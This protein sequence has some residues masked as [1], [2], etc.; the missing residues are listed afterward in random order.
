MGVGYFLFNPAFKPPI[1]IRVTRGDPE[2]VS[3]NTWLL[4]VSFGICELM[5]LCC[6]IQLRDLR[7]TDMYKYG[8][9]RGFGFDYISCANYFWE[10][11]AWV[12]FVLL[13]Q[14]PS[15][16]VFLFFTFVRLNNLAQKKHFWYVSELPNYPQERSAFIP[17]LF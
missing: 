5:N 14:T 1:S 9:P 13:V 10:L 2:S 12:C 3:F 6:H 8:I 15:S 17:Y 16:L 4:V 7:P 11:L